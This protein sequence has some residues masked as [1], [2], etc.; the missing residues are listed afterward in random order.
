MEDSTFE[1]VKPATYILECG[2]SRDVVNY[3]R[4]NGGAVVS[5]SHG[6]EPFLARRVPDLRLHFFTLDLHALSLK[7][8]ADVALGLLLNSLRAYVESKLD[9]PT[10]E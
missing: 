9:L 2:T 10:A 3:G 7:L 1:F 8:Y 5:G 6:T 4:S